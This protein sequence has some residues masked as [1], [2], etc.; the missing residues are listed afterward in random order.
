MQK[1]FNQLTKQNELTS[2]TITDYMRSKLVPGD[3]Q[4]TKADFFKRNQGN[5][6]VDLEEIVN[7]LRG[8]D[9]DP[10]RVLSDVE[11]TEFKKVWK[12]SNQNLQDDKTW[13]KL[14]EYFNKLKVNK[15]DSI[16]GPGL[17][18]NKFIP[19]VDILPVKDANTEKMQQEFSANSQKQLDAL[20]LVAT[21]L[22]AVQTA[23]K[24]G[25]KTRSS[26]AQ[27]ARNA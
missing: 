11:I 19:G 18:F 2:A 9:I 27:S 6:D 7:R 1:T 3:W 25:D 15:F 5:L 24:A 20:T 4:G 22:D 16:S 13:D 17:Q 10:N 21:K 23:I 26:I 14:D 8:R 12:G